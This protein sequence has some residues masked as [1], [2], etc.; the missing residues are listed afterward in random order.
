MHVEGNNEMIEWNLYLDDFKCKKP[1]ELENL[2]LNLLETLAKVF[3]TKECG[4]KISG[5]FDG[6]VLDHRILKAS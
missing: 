3:L 5:A 4:G 2:W 1:Q 6:V